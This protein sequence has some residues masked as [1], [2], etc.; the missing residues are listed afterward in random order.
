MDLRFK[1]DTYQD[2]RHNLFLYSIPT[3]ILSGFFAYFFILPEQD[4]DSISEII[5]S[6]SKH[7]T[8]H[9]IAG[10]LSGTI[11]FVLV[12][13]VVVELFK[14]HEFYDQ[15]IIKWRFRYAIDFI[16]PRL[17]QPF[18]N[19]IGTRFYQLAEDN[20]GDF[21]E[22]L[23]YPFVGDRDLKIPK[24]KLVRFYEAITLYWLTQIN[25]VVLILLLGL[26]SLYHF[27]VNSPV[28][29]VSS[30][31]SSLFN[32]TLILILLFCLNRFW[33]RSTL[34]RVRLATEEEIRSIIE[35]HKEELKEKIKQ[36]CSHY[37]IPYGNTS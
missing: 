4:Q 8:I 15:H 9:A 7:P 21:Q 31:Q 20:V 35:D 5:Q 27:I 22:R 28:V 29:T 30:Y 12:A 1:Y 26:I 18:A 11:L 13:F 17:T 16:L 19:K 37:N 25:E 23:Y 10:T 3:L 33:V 14:V 32:N 34:Q 24:N 2:V 36:L 6:I